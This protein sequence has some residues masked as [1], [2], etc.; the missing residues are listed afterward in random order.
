LIDRV[1]ERI[2]AIEA[3]IHRRR[4]RQARLRKLASR[5]GQASRI[6]Q[7]RERESRLQKEAEDWRRLVI[8]HEGNIA[9]VAREMGYCAEASTRA[10]WDLGLWP[11]VAEM[12][13]R[14]R[15]R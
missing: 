14:R 9:A 7:A 4:R 11:L 10:I 13:S 15:G 3:R 5:A 6:V 12:R 8:K 1:Q 2:L